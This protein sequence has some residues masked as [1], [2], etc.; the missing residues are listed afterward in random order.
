M[1][2]H[3][4]PCLCEDI[5]LYTANTSLAN[6]T[7]NLSAPVRLCPFNES[8]S[9][10]LAMSLFWICA[11]FIKGKV[12]IK[13]QII[14]LGGIGRRRRR[15]QVS[16]SVTNSSFLSCG[17]K[18]F[19]IFEGGVPIFSSLTPEILSLKINLPEMF[20]FL[21]K[22]SRTRAYLPIQRN[23]KVRH[24]TDSVIGRKV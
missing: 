9:T 7:P 2:K 23:S 13:P 3:K 19:H 17:Q 10:P 21:E 15:L 24:P 12:F 5:P 8:V 18:I 16:R 4:E 22:C 14:K 6:P 20:F 1:G 11:H